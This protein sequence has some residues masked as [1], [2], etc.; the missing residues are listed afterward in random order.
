MFIL[1]S[2]RLPMQ[3]KRP[4][5]STALGIILCASVFTLIA[6]GGRA[7]SPTPI[8]TT[9]T[10]ATTMTVMVTT[11]PS[12]TPIPTD[13]PA[14]TVTPDPTLIPLAIQFDIDPERIQLID[15]KMPTGHNVILVGCHAQTFSSVNFVF[16][17]NGHIPYS[18]KNQFI[19]EGIAIIQ[20]DFSKLAKGGCYE[21]AVKPIG[22]GSYRTG[23][24]DSTTLIQEYRL[25][26]Y[27]NASRP[28]SHISHYQK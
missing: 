18:S 9:A 7:T 3:L 23:F 4:A 10:T 11:S 2:P 22:T 1:L 8:P 16:T 25:L 6:C 27:S 20:G 15:G 13:T 12:S 5:K 21:M 14:P 19:A 26:H 24:D 28:M 17:R